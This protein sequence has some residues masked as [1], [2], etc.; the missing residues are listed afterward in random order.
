MRK[1]FKFSAISLLV[2]TATACTG[3]NTPYYTD[4]Q[5]DA[6]YDVYY[7]QMARLHELQQN[8]MMA[9]KREDSLVKEL[10]RIRKDKDYYRSAIAGIENRLKIDKKSQRY[11]MVPGSEQND[12]GDYSRSDNT[13]IKPSHNTVALYTGR[14]DRNPPKQRLF[15]GPDAYEVKKASYTLP[16]SHESSVNRGVFKKASYSKPE[17]HD[18]VIPK[19]DYYFNVVFY[20]KDRH[21]ME[22]MY[23]HLNNFNIKDKFMSEKK[24]IGVYAV[25]VGSMYPTLAKAR[26][27]RHFI[28]LKTG[29]IPKIVRRKNTSYRI[30]KR[31]VKNGVIQ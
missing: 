11:N 12:V 15:G 3:M 25:Y 14:I 10:G 16:A 7:A 26:A 8:Y 4:S 20:L 23:S 21:R 13:E 22:Q 19:Q 29:V 24:D 2:L 28:E 9:S 5:R 6:M 18:D 1:E 27:R 17:P 31:L 30:Y